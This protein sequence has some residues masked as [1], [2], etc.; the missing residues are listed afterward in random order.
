MKEGVMIVNCARGGI[1]DEEALDEALASGKVA[2]AALDV[3][4]RAAGHLQ[5]LQP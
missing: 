2:G 3:F 1:L 4:K 5:A